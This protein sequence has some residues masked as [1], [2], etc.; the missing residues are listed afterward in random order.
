VSLREAV[1]RYAQGLDDYLPVL[2][3]LMSVQDLEV[4]MATERTNLM[5]YRVALYRA[6]GGTWTDSLSDPGT[7]A[8]A[9]GADS[10]IIEYHDT[11]SGKEG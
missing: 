2:S 1:S 10:A 4:T 8:D 9:A 6:L 11:N 5:L 7:P 3:A